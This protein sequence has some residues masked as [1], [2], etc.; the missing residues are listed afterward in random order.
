[1]IRNFAELPDSELAAVAD[2][3]PERLLHVQQRYP[4]VTV[5]EN[6]RDFFEM[7]LDAVV[8]ATPPATHYPIGRECLEHNL[9]TLIEKPIAL[10]SRHAEDL[11]HIAEARNLTLMVGHTFEYNAAVRELKHLIDSGE[12]GDIYYIDA[13]RVNLGLFNPN[14]NVLWDLAPHDI[15]IILYLLNQTSASV[16]AQG[17]SCIFKGVHDIAYLNMRF[18]DGMLAHVHVSW[19]D[20]NKTRRITV[21]GSKKMVVYDDIEPLEKIKIYD[22]G[23]EAPPYTD[24][25]GDFQCSYRYGSV[26]I[27]HIKFTEPLRQECKHFLESIADQTQPLSDGYDGLNVVKVLESADWSLHHNGTEQSVYL[28]EPGMEMVVGW[29][30]PKVLQRVS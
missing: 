21:V 27:P 8:V 9:H 2:L 15:S 25:Y 22:K 24:S 12:L 23:V 29:D 7:N 30:K 20:P 6:Y 3:N 13:V 5:T 18:P 28:H 19:L 26:V 10:Q 1:M 4:G 17:T 11:I 14:M 16:S